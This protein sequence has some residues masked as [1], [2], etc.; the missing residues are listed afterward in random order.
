MAHSAASRR[1]GSAPAL[2]LL[3]LGVALAFAAACAPRLA[4]SP[5]PVRFDS[6]RAFEHIRQLVAIGPRPP[7]SIGSEQARR[8][9]RTQIEA[10]GL[11]VVEHPFTAG[12]PLGPLK[13]TNVSVVIPGARKDRLLFGGH[14][15]TKRFPE[16]R[17]VGA[18]DSGSSTAMLL[19]LAR[20]LKARKNPLTVELV[21]FD[22]EEAIV[23]WA[24]DDHTYGSR[25]YVEQARKAGTLKSIRALVLVDMVA[26]RDLTILRES[27]STKWL[28]DLIW[29][30]AARLGHGRFFQDDFQQI[31]DDHVPFVRAGIPAVDIID[32]QYAPW[33]TT[34][35]TLDKVS[36]RSMQIVAD[37]VLDALPKIEKELLR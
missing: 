9:I 10:I 15:D 16:F 6:G 28:T 20:V 11:E 33:H 30:S 12:T 18:N 22:G 25:T 4:A 26:D 2:V 21:F 19:E 13:M 1:L 31:E 36:A 17:F 5:G 27:N 14:Y 32:L 8:Y 35:D 37:V 23:D 34:D 24:R 7:G 29:A 3:L